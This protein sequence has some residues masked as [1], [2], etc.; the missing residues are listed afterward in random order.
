MSRLRALQVALSGLVTKY[1][2]DHL[3]RLAGEGPVPARFR[4]NRKLQMELER[5]DASARAVALACAG[6]TKADP[7]LINIAEIVSAWGLGTGL[8]FTPAER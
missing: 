4:Q 5:L 3:R 1:E 8:P 6:A 2:W 7:G